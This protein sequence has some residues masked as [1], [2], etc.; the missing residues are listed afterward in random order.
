MNVIIPLCDAAV[1]VKISSRPWLVFID[2]KAGS[3][4]AKCVAVK[5]DDKVK[6]LPFIL[7]I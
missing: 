3:G 5:R 4:P 7:D 6:S 2:M 1:T